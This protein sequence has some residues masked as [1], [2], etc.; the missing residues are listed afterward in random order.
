MIHNLVAFGG[1][2]LFWCLLLAVVMFFVLAG[3]CVL[4]ELNEFALRRRLRRGC[5]DR[6]PYRQAVLVEGRRRRG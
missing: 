2:L 6:F 3:W 5:S 1:V 4:A